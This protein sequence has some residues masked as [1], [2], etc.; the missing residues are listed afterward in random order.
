MN[1]ELILK[2]VAKYPQIGRPT[3]I[4]AR[5]DF[6]SMA[7]LKITM[8]NI[9]GKARNVKVIYAGKVFPREGEVID[10]RERFKRHGEIM[11][12]DQVQSYT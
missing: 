11:L 6:K 3:Q 5:R 10:A 2:I 1:K 8:N 4:L 12:Y 9:I 7:D